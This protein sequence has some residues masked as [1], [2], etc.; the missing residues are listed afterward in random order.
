MDKNNDGQGLIIRLVDFEQCYIP[1]S[2]SGQWSSLFRRHRLSRCGDL[3]DVVCGGAISDQN[4]CRLTAPQIRPAPQIHPTRAMGGVSKYFSGLS[5]AG[6]VC[7]CFSGAGEVY[8]C[9]YGGRGNVYILLRPH[10]R[11]SSLVNYFSG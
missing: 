9:L 11:R 8:K 4:E 6:E 2:R 7:K 3:A 1:V 10:R 5:G